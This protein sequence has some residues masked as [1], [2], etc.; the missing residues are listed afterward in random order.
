MNKDLIINII[1][2]PNNNFRSIGILYTLKSLLFKFN[3]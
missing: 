2:I 3:T 1:A